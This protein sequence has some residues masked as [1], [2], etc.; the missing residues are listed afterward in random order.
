MEL[1]ATSISKRITSDRKGK[2]ISD[3]NN[4]TT[5][6]TG[7]ETT[8]VGKRK[9]YKNT[10]KPAA[11][12]SSGVE[13]SYHSLGGP[14]YLCPNYNA[15]MWDAPEPLKWLLDYTQP[16]TSAL[17]DLIRVYNG[18]FCFTSFG[19]RIDH[20]INKGRGLYTFRINRQNYYKIRSLLPTEGT[21]PRCNYQCEITLLSERTTSKQYN[22]PT[23]AEVAAL[24]TNDFGDGEPTR[25]IVVCKNTAHQKRISELHPS[26]M[27]LQ[28]PLLFP[29][30]EDGYHEKIL[31]HTNKAAFP[32]VLGLNSFVFSALKDSR[33]KESSRKGQ[34]RIKTRQKGEALKKAQE[35]DKSG[36][37]PDK[38]G[39]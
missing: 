20:S 17:R 4:V 8:Y 37:K 14:T 39:K 22:A 34:N 30:G 33:V 15:T 13:V 19:A 23:V 26:Y 3:P 32:G 25:D 5:T 2:P 1:G 18:M 9:K 31:Y 24:I 35:K 7:R 16:S 12:A 29:Y 28:Y 11:L 21:Q 27:A 6:K 38:N 10:R 36:S